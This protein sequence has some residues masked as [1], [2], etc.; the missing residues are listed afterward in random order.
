MPCKLAATAF[1]G[2]G[3]GSLR[4]CLCAS[5]KSD[6]FRLG[7]GVFMVSHCGCRALDEAVRAVYER[8]LVRTGVSLG[9]LEATAAADAGD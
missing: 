4:D 3:E 1:P 7:T 6:A 2:S 5:L 9:T 8:L